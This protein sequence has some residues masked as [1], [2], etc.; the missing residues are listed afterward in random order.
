[1]SGLPSDRYD[2]LHGMREHLAAASPPSPSGS[3]WWHEAVSVP[4]LIIQDPLPV[5]HTHNKRDSTT[6]SS[7]DGACPAVCVASNAR[8]HS[9]A[10]TSGVVCCEEDLV[11][12]KWLYTTTTTA[13]AAATG[14]AVPTTTTTMTMTATASSDSQMEALIAAGRVFAALA[15]NDSSSRGRATW[16]SRGVAGAAAVHCL[17]NALSIAPTDAR[18]LLP[19]GTA[20]LNNGHHRDA[21]RLFT[22]AL[23]SPP[24]SPPAAHARHSAVTHATGSGRGAGTGGAAGMGG[25]AA[26]WL[27]AHGCSDAG[28][29]GRVGGSWVCDVDG[30]SATA[31]RVA[32]AALHSGTRAHAADGAG[33]LAA[34]AHY[35]LGRTHEAQGFV[36]NAL[37]SYDSALALD[38]SHQDAAARRHAIMV[39]T[40]GTQ[41]GGSSQPLFV[42]TLML[43]VGATSVTL[44]GLYVFVVR[45]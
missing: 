24:P 21:E 3:W 31:A 35:W 34:D 18:A 45:Q 29:G 2:Y 32:R 16:G 19:L 27:R 44:V 12:L 15:T 37:S 4:H 36:Q 30:L 25:A 8:L 38:P 9:G 6:S 10:S 7:K 14:R 11:A 26:A 33:A 28:G 13:A 41:A 40:A 22:R 1:M 17:R 20:M 5:S 43:I 23:R 42:Q 39:S